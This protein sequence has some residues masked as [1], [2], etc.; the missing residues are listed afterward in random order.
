MDKEKHLKY[1]KLH[2][3]Q[4][5]IITFWSV[6]SSTSFLKL[7]KHKYKLEG[8]GDLYLITAKYFGVT[9]ILP[10]FITSKIIHRKN[11]NY[12]E[13]DIKLVGLLCKM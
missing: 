4:I 2:I 9:E 8:Y 12:I 5:I 1:I 13:Y 11:I 7:N 10:K 6:F 3:Y